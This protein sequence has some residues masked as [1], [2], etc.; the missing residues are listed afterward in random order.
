[1]TQL[2]DSGE[3]VEDSSFMGSCLAFKVPWVASLSSGDSV[4]SFP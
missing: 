3:E 4:L 2:S 1:M